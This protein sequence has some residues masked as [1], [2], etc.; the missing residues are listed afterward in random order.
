MLTVYNAG[1]VLFSGVRADVVYVVQVGEAVSRISIPQSCEYPSLNTHEVLAFIIQ[2]SCKFMGL[3][4][5]NMF[6]VYNA[7]IVLSCWVAV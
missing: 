5:N 6:T 1:I 3:I 4:V 2:L 7:S